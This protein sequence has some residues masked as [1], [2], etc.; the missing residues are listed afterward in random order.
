MI[1]NPFVYSAAG[2]YLLDTYAGA[3]AAYSLR[4]LYAAWAS[5]DVVLVRR[6]SDDAESGFTA[7]EVSDGT[8]L[9]WVGTGGT[10]NGF[11]TTWYDQSGNAKNAVQAT[12]TKQPKIVA[13]GVLVAG[14]IDLDG[15]DDFLKTASDVTI[16][17]PSTTFSVSNI[18][19]KSNQ[20][21][22]DSG[23]GA[24]GR[25]ALRADYHIVDQ[26]AT[27]AASSSSTVGATEL[28]FIKFDNLDTD[29]RINGGTLNNLSATDFTAS[30]VTP[31]VIGSYYAAG[32]AFFDGTLAEIILYNSDESSNRVAIEGNI[33]SYYGITI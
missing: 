33:A 21:M 20:Y 18:R 30:S 8:M 22:F 13:A 19:T 29:H 17:Y 24:G 11:V 15:T 3:V 4:V 28:N 6:S 31:F 26:D 16:N 25:R 2:A 32:G 5:S 12:T 1:L 10:D 7:T 14:G 23:S 27:S 9:T